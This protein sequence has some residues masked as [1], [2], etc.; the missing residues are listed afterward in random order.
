MLICAIYAQ[1]IYAI[2]I[3]AQGIL[4]TPISTGTKNRS[5]G[6]RKKPNLSRRSLWRSRIQTRRRARGGPKRTRRYARGGPKRT[7]RYARGGP[8]KP[9]PSRSIDQKNVF[10]MEKNVIAG[11]AGHLAVIFLLNRYIPR[12]I[13]TCVYCNWFWFYFIIW[14]ILPCV[15]TAHDVSFWGREWPVG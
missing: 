3:Y 15:N 10:I 8:N 4:R 6:S 12:V 9:N 11:P 14:R 2:G 7:R 1:G 13:V 5:F